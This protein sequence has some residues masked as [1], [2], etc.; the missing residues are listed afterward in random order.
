MSGGRASGAGLAGGGGAD[1]APFGGLAVGAAGAEAAGAAWSC[2]NATDGMAIG[3]ASARV[4]QHV[5]AA[6]GHRLGRRSITSWLE[7]KREPP[8]RLFGRSPPLAAVQRRGGWRPFEEGLDLAASP[9]VVAQLGRVARVE[10]AGGAG[11][12]ACSLELL[13][14]AGIVN[15]CP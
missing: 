1:V 12:D 8:S 7:R 10:I 4:Q 3:V 11:F 9:G 15:P 13:L 14:R 2:A 5:R 6:P